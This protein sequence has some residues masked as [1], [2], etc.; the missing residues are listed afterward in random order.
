MG[1]LR[2]ICAL[3]CR[4]V[5]LAASALG[6]AASIAALTFVATAAPADPWKGTAV[7]GDSI[8]LGTGRAFCRDKPNCRVDAKVGIASADVIELV[9]SDARFN[10]ISAGSNDP[11][12]PDLEDNLQAIRRRANGFVVWLVPQH[13][14]AAEL[15]EKVAFQFG[16]PAI[17]PKAGSDRIHPA[18][19]RELARTIELM[20]AR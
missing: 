8:A 14:R 2:L 3:L 19:Y 16:D 7:V 4:A 9:K 18:D 13:K 1:A 12:N 15:V 5:T 6:L 11:D 17:A 10:I 20:L